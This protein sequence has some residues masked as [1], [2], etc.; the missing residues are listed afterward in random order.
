MV[1]MHIKLRAGLSHPFLEMG[2]EP[3][4]FIEIGKVSGVLT[5]IG[6]FDGYIDQAY[7]SPNKYNTI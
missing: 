5:K 4:E 3:M 6:K 1:M 2:S 7:V